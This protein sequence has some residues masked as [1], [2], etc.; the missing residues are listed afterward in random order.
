MPLPANQDLVNPMLRALHDLGGEAESAD[1][2]EAVFRVL[3]PPLRP[4]DFVSLSKRLT[5]VRN[6]LL[7]RE[8]VT[9]PARGMWELTERGAAEAAT[10]AASHRRSRTG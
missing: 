5:G 7:Q 6:D 3:S 2:D 10:A 8:W 9:H 1:I 4:R